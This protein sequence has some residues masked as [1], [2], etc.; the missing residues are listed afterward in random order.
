MYISTL[1]LQST[2]HFKRMLVFIILSPLAADISQSFC[3]LYCCCSLSLSVFYYCS[4]QINV[5]LLLPLLFASLFSLHLTASSAAPPCP[6]PHDECSPATCRCRRT[7]INKCQQ[8]AQSSI[9]R[10]VPRGV[11][12][13]HF[14]QIRWM[15]D[16]QIHHKCR[17]SLQQVLKLH[18][19]KVFYDAFKTS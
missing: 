8:S 3:I 4:R 12:T 9:N 5:N 18:M 17:R 16:G 10:D 15:V 1:Y 2:F 19:A 14:T 7:V 6:P 11:Y 13:I